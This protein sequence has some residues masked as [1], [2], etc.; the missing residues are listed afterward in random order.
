M[1]HS[2]GY[3]SGD[4]VDHVLAIVEYEAAHRGAR[5]D[6]R[7]SGVRHENDPVVVEKRREH[8]P[9]ETAAVGGLGEPFVGDSETG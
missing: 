4:R 7:A 6:R 5:L 1:R 2:M 9:E 3:Q 8:R